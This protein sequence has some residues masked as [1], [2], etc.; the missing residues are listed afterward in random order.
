MI[1]EETELN[2]ILASNPF[3]GE[4]D[5]WRNDL[6]LFK[7]GNRK[8]EDLY[9]VLSSDKAN[10]S[11]YQRHVAKHSAGWDSYLHPEVLPQ[12]FIGDPRAPVWY[13]LLNPGYSFPDRYDHLGICSCDTNK[14]FIGSE[15]EENIFDRGRDRDEVLA[16][17]QSLLLNQF[18]LKQNAP[19]YILDDS[20]NTL[21]DRK[22]YK[23]KGGYRWW[24]TVL[25][26]ANQPNGFLLPEC[27]VNP[28]ATSV[29]KKLFV[30]E[31]CPYHST[32]FDANVLW[33]ENEYMK[34]WMNLISWAVKVGKK[35]IV[36]S[37]RVFQLIKNRG[38]A[39]DDINH[40]RFSS[41]RNV[42]LTLKNLKN[43][44][45]LAAICQALKD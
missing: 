29:G 23:K 11:N 8:L 36:R 33:N 21:P 37:E 15:P 32:N 45:A 24:R 40:V 1:E 34:F 4:L 17:R 41:E 3:L 42:A 38:L 16:K 20:F 2:Q 25:F 26:G 18:Q 19:F 12:P 31:C 28:D 6:L 7:R 10:F 43:S 30:L 13:L 35:F 39:I 22:S 14:L 5:N 9:F 44:C 27:G